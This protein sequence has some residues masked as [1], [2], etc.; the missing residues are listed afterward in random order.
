MVMRASE[1]GEM[2]AG[3]ADR[4]T[5]DLIL[6]VVVALGALSCAATSSRHGAGVPLASGARPVP[7]LSGA[8]D[9]DEIAEEGADTFAPGL[10]LRAG[11]AT[12]PQTDSHEVAPRVTFGL[13]C[14]FAETEARRLEGGLSYAA[15]GQDPS[16][17]Y[18]LGAD[19]KYV[20]YLGEAGL[21]SWSAGGGLLFEDWYGTHP[22][23]HRATFAYAGASIGY[24]VPMGQKG[25]DLRL[26]ASVP[27]GEGLNALTI[28]AFTVGYDF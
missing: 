20:G 23:G 9:D 11:L 27:M 24:W 1:R 28:A 12:Y 26:T 2:S 18:Y 15:S 16:E 21:V 25:V 6:P 22:G 7:S 3:A 8:S 14:H 17:N 10:G 5:L 4:A 19:F 13:Y